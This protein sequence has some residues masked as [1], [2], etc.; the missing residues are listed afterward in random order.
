[1]SRIAI[2]GAG[3]AG[4]VSAWMLED[5]HEVCVYEASSWFGGHARTIEVPYEGG[6]GLA[7]TGFRFVITDSFMRVRA[8]FEALGVE[9]EEQAR[10]MTLMR[11]GRAPLVLPPRNL[12]QTYRLASSPR[13]FADL[14]RL[15]RWNACGPEFLVSNDKTTTLAEFCQREGF[16]R[17]FVDGLLLPMI[18]GSWGAS[19]TQMNEFP[20]YNVFSVF[21]GATILAI[22]GG[23]SAYIAKLVADIRRAILY[24]NRAVVQLRR[25]EDGGVWVIDQ[26]GDSQRFDEVV[27]ATE[28]PYAVALAAEVDPERAELL[29]QFSSFEATIVVHTDTS[30]MP[31]RVADW[32]MVNVTLPD[33]PSE[34][35]SQTDCLDWEQG[36]PV[37]RTWI[38]GR[39]RYPRGAVHEQTFLHQL[40]TAKTPALR[41]RLLARQ[42]ERGLWFTGMYVGSVD[43]HE[44]ALES[45]MAV[46]ERLSPD[47]GRLAE[48]RKRSSAIAAAAAA[49]GWARRVESERSAL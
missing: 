29:G 4:L 30:V 8:L 42:G 27:I 22:R 12:A 28:C 34:Q 21:L 32:S 45:A 33:D 25:A 15:R 19:R 35:P 1:M 5:Q 17:E 10:G 41:E 9:V 26:Q 2:I 16:S 46:A 14:L 49:P 36:V 24:R 20:I 39:E 18:A 7:E 11:P 48:L 44:A 13:V 40:V 38:H 43:N 23:A 37:L 31:P 6:V 3:G 47:S